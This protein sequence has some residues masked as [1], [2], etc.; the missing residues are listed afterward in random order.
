MFMRIRNISFLYK[1]DTCYCANSKNKASWS[2][3]SVE[4]QTRRVVQLLN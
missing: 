1:L 4:K 2:I 3:F